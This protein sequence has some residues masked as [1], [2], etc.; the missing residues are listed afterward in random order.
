MSAPLTPSDIVMHISGFFLAIF[1][2]KLLLEVSAWSISF[3]LL[4]ILMCIA[5]QFLLIV[6]CYKFHLISR[7][8]IETFFLVPSEGCIAQWLQQCWKSIGEVVILLWVMR[9][10]N[11]LKS[12]I[13]SIGSR[14]LCCQ[15]KLSRCFALFFYFSLFYCKKNQ[16]KKKK[17]NICSVAKKNWLKV[18]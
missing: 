1:Y 17:I 6:S 4:L 18:H 5:L 15:N 7:P 13:R 14:A 12:S 2:V 3:F 10:S 9:F 8:N 11:T 16:K